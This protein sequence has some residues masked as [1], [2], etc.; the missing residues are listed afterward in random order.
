VDCSAWQIPSLYR[1]N[2][3]ATSL[4]DLAGLLPGLFFGAFGQLIWINAG[5]MVLIYAGDTSLKDFARACPGFFLSGPDVG[6]A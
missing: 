2:G 3:A 6:P 1:G 4:L 5:G